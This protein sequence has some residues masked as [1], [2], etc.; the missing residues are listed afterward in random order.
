MHSPLSVTFKKGIQL[1][2]A[3][4]LDSPNGVTL[5]QNDNSLICNWSLFKKR[6]YIVIKILLKITD[7]QLLT[8]K[9][10]KLLKDYTD[11]SY[12]ITDVDKI[13]KINYTNGISEKI[14]K[15]G[16]FS[17]PIMA[18]MFCIII[19]TSLTLDFYH[20]RYQ[21]QLLPGE[22]YYLKAK[23]YNT[24]KLFGEKT[25]KIVSLQDVNEAQKE[26]KVL[27]VK[28]TIPLW[29]IIFIIFTS[30]FILIPTVIWFEECKTNKRVHDFFYKRN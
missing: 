8:I 3:K 6:E 2:D 1:L 30:I 22:S 28:E 4:V 12:R 23:S 7:E 19:L 17:Y 11:I 13:K 26:T 20:V 18:L 25:K 16:L 27:L 5:I 9:S 24:V 29:F 14:S 10:N 15:T 21:S